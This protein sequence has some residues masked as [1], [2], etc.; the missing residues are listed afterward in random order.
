MG[1]EGRFLEGQLLSLPL[2]L[3][4][5]KKILNFP[6]PWKISIYLL[7]AYMELSKNQTIK[8]ALSGRRQ[9]MTKSSLLGA[10]M[11]KTLS[12]PSPCL[13]RILP[14]KSSIRNFHSNIYHLFPRNFEL[15][16]L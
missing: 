11:V 5:R 7:H 13:L 15:A 16:V 9:E 3:V 2:L 6:Y 4:T 12:G 1:K 8:L 10:Q 14:Q